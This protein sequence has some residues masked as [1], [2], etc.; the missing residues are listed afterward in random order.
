MLFKNI[1]YLDEDFQIAGPAYILVEDSK[2]AQISEQE[3]EAYSGEVYEGKGEFLLP[4]LVNAHCHV[5]MTLLRGYGEGLPLQ[6]WLEEKVFPFEDLLTD[7][8][9][10]WGSL[11]GIAE[12]LASGCVSFT[13]MYMNLGGII[14]AVEESGIKA[15]LTHGCAAPVGNPDFKNTNAYT[16]TMTIL[17]HLKSNPQ[18]RIKAELALHAEYTSDENTASTL[19]DFAK[20][21][22]LAIQ[23]H[24]SETKKEHEE[25]KVRRQGRTPLRYFY[26]LG[27]FERPLI[28]AHG[29]WLEPGDYALIAEHY[30]D[31]FPEKNILDKVKNNQS[32]NKGMYAPIT[33][34]HNPSSNLKLASGFANLKTWKET[35]GINIAIGTDGASS[36]NNLNMWEETYLASLLQKAVS[37]DAAF[38]GPE[39]S[40]KYATLGGRLAQGRSGGTIA[41]GEP[42]DLILVDLE[43]YATTP[44]YD[45]LANMLYAGD[46]HNIVMTMVDGN[47]LYQDGE[48][49]TLDIER[50]RAE[51]KRIAH[52]KNNALK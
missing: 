11:L 30:K 5:P 10:Y 42:A 47:I 16:G 40:L 38:M 50:V 33:L 46:K 41:E 24:I 23:L 4:G 3:P 22:D 34:V 20:E 26:D 36:N 15:N 52:E 25:A 31:S 1:R 49:K 14:K 13:D 35:P 28:L 37:G 21:Q 45:P 2:I 6:R 27:Y 8:D 9:A 18:S 12:L 48:F 43:D 32:E 7:E 44:C 19:L 17:E 29:I 51:V 39:E